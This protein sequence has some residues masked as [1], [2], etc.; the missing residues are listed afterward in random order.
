MKLWDENKS[1]A[2]HTDLTRIGIGGGYLRYRDRRK[3][4][5]MRLRCDMPADTLAMLQDYAVG[6]SGPFKLSG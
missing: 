2:T 1:N 5:G 6:R 3:K 4:A